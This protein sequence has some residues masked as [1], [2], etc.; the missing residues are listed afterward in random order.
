MISSILTIRLKQLIRI[1]NSLGLGRFIFIVIVLA[2]IV[3]F[4]FMSINSR[5][6]AYF[7]GST[8][9]ILI[10]A[11]HIKRKDLTFLR[12]H[13]E[14]FRLLLVIE[15]S[16]ISIPV[17]T[18]LIY[19]NKYAEFVIFLIL[20]TGI[21]LRTKSMR[22]LTLNTWLQHLIPDQCFEW[23]SGIRSSLLFLVPLYI[24]GISASG[25][26]ATVPVIMII[27]GLVTVGFNEKNEPLPMLL[28]FERSANNLLFIKI[29]NH[30]VLFSLFVIPLLILYLFRNPEYWYIVTIIFLMNI[31][32]QSYS[33]LTKYAFYQP[34][35][36]SG[37]QIFNI[38]GSVSVLVPFLLPLVVVLGIR[39]Y[40]KSVSNLNQYLY[41]YH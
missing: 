29:R 16:L 25:W 15:Y 2:M 1:V 22:K 10:L 23:K 7:T 41:D 21:A 5:E 32:I 36:S 40:F 12:S 39:F 4:I 27:F 19:W 18:G 34:H 11:L 35:I 8:W 24:V 26:P 14:K 9:L 37:N 13:I 31:L 28:V 3:L 17:I 20:L 38:L 33:V 6:G 30:L